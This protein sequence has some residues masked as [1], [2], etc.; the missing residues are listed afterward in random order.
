MPD[1]YIAGRSTPLVV[2]APGVL[3]ND[4]NSPG[5]GPL[6]ATLQTLPTSGTVTL[7]SNGGFVYTP[8]AGYLGPDSF[9]YYP[10][11]TAG[12]SAAT[13]VSITVVPVQPATQFRIDRVAG[14]QVT[15]RWDP[16]A[17][18]P[19]PTGY[20]IEGG[21]APGAPVA[22]AVTGPTPALTFTAPSGA[23][24]LRVTSLDGAM[25][26][27]V[28][29]EVPLYVNVPVA[30]SAPVSLTGLVNDT[31]MALSWKPTFGGAAPTDTILDVSGALVGSVSVG[32]VDTFTFAGVPPG[33]YTFTVRSANATGG[34]AAAT[35]VTLTFPAAC[36]GVP[37]PPRNYLY[38]R[39]GSVLHLLWDPPA[40]GPAATAYVLN[41]TGSFV[42][43]V[44]VG[45]S[46]NPS[47]AVPPGSYSVSVSALNAC[48]ASVPTA[49]QTVVVP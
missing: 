11:N 36:T 22:S 14:N 32:A 40:T 41:V 2:A 17:A 4:L 30:P 31:S 38:Y 37:A 49:A 13:T 44:P 43:A 48:G 42:G 20:L 7:N 15:L 8:V 29:N 25:A 28:S 21:L 34:S 27:G 19:P 6:T 35:P 39:E 16:P 3:A 9:T 23:F 45:V 24:F 5:S 1:A 18:G 47:G 33:T 12:S 26:S 46:R 10:S